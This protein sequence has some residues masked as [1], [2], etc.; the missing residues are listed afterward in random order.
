MGEKYKE[1]VRDFLVKITS[2][3]IVLGEYIPPVVNIVRNPENEKIISN[4]QLY[5]NGF[6]TNKERIAVISSLFRI[7]LKR[8][9]SWTSVQ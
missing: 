5:I 7:R 2:K 6:K 4:A 3:P 1:R 9:K 8:I